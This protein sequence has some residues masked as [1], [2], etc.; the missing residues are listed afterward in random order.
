MPTTLDFTVAALRKAVPHF[1]VA[2]NGSHFNAQ[3][4]DGWLKFIDCP[5]VLKLLRHTQSKGTTETFVHILKIDTKTVSCSTPHE[6]DW[7][8]DNFLMQYCNLV[9]AWWTTASSPKLFFKDH[10]L[11]TNLP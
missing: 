2:N 11:P 10:L 7:R 4:K 6:L 3:C 5:H 9:Y 8:V 1:P